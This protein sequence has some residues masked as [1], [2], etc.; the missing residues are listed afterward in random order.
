MKKINEHF[1]KFLIYKIC[2]K[3]FILIFFCNF[4]YDNHINSYLIFPL[5]YL[6]DKYYT[7]IKDVPKKSH[8]GIIQEIYFK[9]FIKK[10]K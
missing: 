5:D 9:N 4:I 7:F 10:Y 8:E 1:F 2:S 3:Y 6:S